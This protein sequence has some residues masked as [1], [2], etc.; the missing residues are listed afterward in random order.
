MTEC[1]YWWDKQTSYSVLCVFKC[2]RVSVGWLY[3]VVPKAVTKFDSPELRFKG[4]LPKELSAVTTILYGH[5]AYKTLHPPH[6]HKHA[7]TQSR[8]SGKCYFLCM[9]TAK[10]I[11]HTDTHV[12]VKP[13][14]TNIWPDLYSTFQKRKSYQIELLENNIIKTTIFIVYSVSA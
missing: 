5:R 2:D 4:T 12:W 3:L 6:T 9:Y 10:T 8:S 14:L 1:E 11:M 7:R 13:F